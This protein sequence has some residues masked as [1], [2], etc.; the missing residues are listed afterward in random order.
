MTPY[1]SELAMSY[2][3]RFKLADDYIK[4][5][6][7]IVGSIEDPF[8]RQ[9]YIGFVATSAVTALELAIKDILHEFAHKK[10]KVFG[11]FVEDIYENI[12]GRIQLRELKNTHIKRFGLKYVKRFEKS[13]DKKEKKS[14]SL[15][16]RSVKSSYGNIITWRHTFVH[17]GEV[18]QNASYD[19]AVRA[20]EDSKE[21]I[22]VLNSTMV[23]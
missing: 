6:N 22:H 3:A 20:F 23:R 8:I 18:A 15:A 4:H 12:N 16:S 17:S 1:F 10:H 14:L 11:A 13:I 19:E 21:V 9:R 7:Q 2:I 5:T